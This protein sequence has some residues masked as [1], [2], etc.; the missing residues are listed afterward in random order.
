[1]GIPRQA[2][3]EAVLAQAREPPFELGAQAS[4]GAQA[5]GIVD[6]VSH[7]QDLLGPEGIRQLQESGGFGLAE[8]GRGVADRGELEARSSSSGG[9]PVRTGKSRPVER[10]SSRVTSGRSNWMVSA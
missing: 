1:M 7:E 10:S 5:P 8:V 9:R 4:G 2:E 6:G 3:A